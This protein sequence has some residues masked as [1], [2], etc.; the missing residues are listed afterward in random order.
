M[1]CVVIAVLLVSTG[2]T[3]FAASTL[4]ANRMKRLVTQRLVGIALYFLSALVWADPRYARSQDGVGVEAHVH[5][6]RDA[7]KVETRV[8]W[9]S[10]KVL[11]L[12]HLPKGKELSQAL[13]ERFTQNQLRELAAS[14]V[15]MP[16][17]VVDRTPFAEFLLVTLM[18]AFLKSAD[19]DGLV[20]LLSTRCPHLVRCIGGPL[21]VEY[22]LVT[23]GNRL[24]HPILVLGEA[25]AKCRVPEVR[26]ELAAA[27]RRGFIGLGVQGK[28]DAE[29]VRNA[30]K[31]YVEK[32]DRVKVNSFYSWNSAHFPP[33]DC[34]ER[35][36]LFR[37]KSSADSPPW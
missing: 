25:Y 22:C 14:C 9:D 21:H 10:P 17:S 28:D 32:K 11:S 24:Q 30:M 5:G 23:A 16:T 4:C 8:S 18:F 27:V 37:S 19:R 33:H 7:E 13:E 2:T 31:W 35:N 15:T 1:E 29:L 26:Q 20:T 36:P 12:E 34:Y 6:K 3:L